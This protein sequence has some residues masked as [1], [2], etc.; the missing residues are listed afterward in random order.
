MDTVAYSPLYLLGFY[1]QSQLR[2]IPIVERYRENSYQGTSLIV[3]Y[4]FNQQLQIYNSKIVLRAKFEGLK[5]YMY[6]WPVTAVI[7]GSSIIWTFLLTVIVT[8]WYALSQSNAGNQRGDNHNYRLI[9]KDTPAVESEQSASHSKVAPSEANTSLQSSERT[10]ID[11]V[12]SSVEVT[13]LGVTP[14]DLT[15]RI[16][17]EPTIHR[18]RNPTAQQPST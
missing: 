6:E 8:S 1:D 17:D 14:L 13:S 2:K 15:D 11:A 18:R 7:V 9:L 12:D 16:K 5:H 10:T 4:V 3:V